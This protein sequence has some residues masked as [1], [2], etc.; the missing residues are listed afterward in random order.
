MKIEFNFSFSSFFFLSLRF[1]SLYR[2]GKERNK[3]LFS[4]SAIL[5]MPSGIPLFLLIPPFFSFIPSLFLLFFSFRSVP[6]N[7]VFGLLRSWGTFISGVL[8]RAVVGMLYYIVG[9][10]FHFTK[11]QSGH[12]STE[13]PNTT[14]RGLQPHGGVPNRHPPHATPEFSI[15][16]TP[17]H[18]HSQ[19]P[20]P[21]F[22][23]SIASFSA[24]AQC[25]GTFSMRP[26]LNFN[27][28]IS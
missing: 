6:R 19:P 3:I 23:H 22:L 17:T 13:S 8:H 28:A 11:S 5:Q 10:P 14:S 25:H 21:A 20:I 16:S 26:S 24:P 7:H 9:E 1:F 18:P 4:F 15:I 12:T 2:K 27:V